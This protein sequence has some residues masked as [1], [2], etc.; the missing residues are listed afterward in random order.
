VRPSLQFTPTKWALIAQVVGRWRRYHWDT[1]PGRLMVAEIAFV[2]GALL[3]GCLGV[4]AAVVRANTTRDIGGHLEPLNAS[5]TT[6]Y[7]SLADADAT[8]AAGFLAGGVEPRE[9]Q[10]RYVRDLMTATT[11][12]A[13]ASTQAGGELVASR[14]IADITTQLPVY[15]GLVERARANNRDGRPV[16][17]AYL[18]R[19]S[20]LMQNSILAEAA[21][22]QR[23]QAAQLDA[24]YERLGP[25]LVGVVAVGA[26]SLAGLVWLQVFLFQRT[27][28]VFN[29][30]LVVAT[31]AVLAGTVWWMAA[32]SVSANSLASARGHSRSVSDALGPAQI[33]ALQA[34]SVESLELVTR[35]AGPTEPDFA[36]RMQ[37]L[38]RDNGAGGALGAARQFVSDQTGTTLVQAAIDDAGGYAAAHREVRR[39]DDVGDYVKAVNAAVNTREPSAATA[40]DRLDSALTVAVAHE[41]DVFQRDIAHAQNWLTG[42]PIGTGGVALVIAVAVVVGVRQRLEE[43][44]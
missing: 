2:V 29:I 7:R 10:A 27:Q 18:R 13:Q 33:A 43:Y 6:L 4:Y 35:D 42:L 11:N 39:L 3:A 19:A 25:V 16:G 12:L 37:L 5:V 26:V 38:E 8:A 44:R 17:V 32:E 20:E 14:R 28:R 23:R 34:R 41:R 31:V 30:G 40:F 15:T 9:V 22:L 21:E 1:L 36:A 24:A